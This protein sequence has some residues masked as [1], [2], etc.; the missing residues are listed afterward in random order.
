M[1]T[2][3]LLLIL[4]CVSLL[5]VQAQPG[6]RRDRI[7]GLLLERFD[8]DRD[9]RLSEPERDRLRDRLVQWQAR[10]PGSEAV[11]LQG[12]YGQETSG[13][14]SR[15]QH[16]EIRDRKRDKVVPVQVTYPAGGGKN[17]VIIWSHGLF[18]SQDNY[19]PLVQHWARHGYLVLQPSHSDSLS[20]GEGDPRLGMAGNVKDWASRP[21]DVSFLISN[22]TSHPKLAPYSDV[23]RIGVGGHSFGGHTTVLV[24]GAVPAYGPPLG[25]S[26]VKAF[27]SV[28]PPG[29]S[30]L[31]PESAWRGLARPMLFV[32]GDNDDSPGGEKAAWRRE[33]FEGCP[34][35]DKY[36]LWIANAHHNFGGIS[37]V[38]RR[39][40]PANPDQ[41]EIVKS[42]S[43]AFWDAYLKQEEPARQVLGSGRLGGDSAKLY[44]WTRR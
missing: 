40:Q 21:E 27:L 33:S 6:D 26:R 3:I 30:R 4:S 43:L 13:G 1:R 2:V 36:L 17:P 19:Q 10:S 8:A 9:G 28:S 44:R 25:D 35:G 38:T 24:A 42:A 15:Q 41:V 18:G 34:A 22:L 37:G 7:Q 5:A 14:V 23:S 29:N 16:L 31:L 11:S 12:L 20:R 39:G 32:S